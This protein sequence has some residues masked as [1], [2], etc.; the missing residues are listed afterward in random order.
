MKDVA[1]ETTDSANGTTYLLK[2]IDIARV[3]SREADRP[4]PA[5]LFTDRFRSRIPAACCAGI[6][7][8]LEARSTPR[9][10]SLP[11]QPISEEA[12][13]TI[14]GITGRN[15]RLFNRLLTQI[16]R[17]SKSTR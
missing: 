14:L 6:R 1:Q 12:S 17:R 2:L 7:R 15:F 8:L 16:E 5:A 10:V 3:W 4:L 11:E 13:A 9:T